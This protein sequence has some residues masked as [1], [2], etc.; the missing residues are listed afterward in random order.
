MII[1]HIG[2][3]VSDY[4]NSKAFYTKALKTLNITL[5]IEIKGWAGFGVGEKPE[6]W[7]GPHYTV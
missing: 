3:S 1:D 5:I 6:F 4:E 7:M 2:L